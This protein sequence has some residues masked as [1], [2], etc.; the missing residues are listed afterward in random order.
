[1]RVITTDENYHTVLH[2]GRVNDIEII[3]MTAIVC[4]VPVK[5][6]QSPLKVYIAFKTS[7]SGGNTE[8]RSKSAR[9]KVEKR[10][11]ADLKVYM[12]TLY[13]EPNE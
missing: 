5:G 1:M 11:N 13:K 4:K 8:L 9:V 7:A 12:S 2:P 10:V 3:E 6:M